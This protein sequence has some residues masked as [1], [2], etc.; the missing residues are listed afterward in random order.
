[1]KIRV[2]YNKDNKYEVVSF[3]SDEIDIE[4]VLENGNEID[5]SFKKNKGF[6]REK[7]KPNDEFEEVKEWV[8]R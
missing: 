7:L 4:I 8:W 6:I 1:M 2:G 3:E 5:G